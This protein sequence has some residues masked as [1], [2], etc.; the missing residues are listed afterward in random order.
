MYIGTYIHGSATITCDVYDFKLISVK[1]ISCWN[2]YEYMTTFS[3]GTSICM[4][5]TLSINHCS[6]NYIIVVL[7]HT[8][9]YWQCK[10]KIVLIKY[11]LIQ[12]EKFEVQL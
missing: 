2:S 1:P 4:Y 7:A 10:N 3:V 8:N 12:F 6:F 5:C 9:A 11:Y